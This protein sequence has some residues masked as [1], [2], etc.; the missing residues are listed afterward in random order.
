MNIKHILAIGSAKGGVGKST[1]CA[2]LALA[3][4]DN[5]RVGI[6]DADIY[7]PSQH[8]LFQ[9]ESSKPE[10]IE[11]EGKKRL[12]PIS[13]QGIVLNSMGF[14]MSSEEAVIW[15]GPMLSNALKQLIEATDWGDL[16][17]LIVDMPPGTG[18]PY[19][20]IAKEIKPTA[21]ILVTTNHI[22]SLSDTEKSKIALQK[23]GIPIIGYINNMSA[24]TCPHCNE[25]L[26]SSHPISDKFLKGIPCIG[27]IIR[28]SALQL[29]PSIDSAKFFEE[30]KAN[31]VKYL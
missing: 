16:D 18:D 21:S 23:L 11:R 14:V 1:I 7:G 30:I 25:L 22:L 6:L 24:E 27:S 8:L 26:H 5:Y 9:T 13:A 20:T 31:V 19:L 2:N 28:H 29:A 10:I 3:M 17:I 12:K 15:R 4:S